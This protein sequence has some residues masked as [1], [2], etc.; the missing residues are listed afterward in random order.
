MGPSKPIRATPRGGWDFVSL[1]LTRKAWLRLRIQLLC[2]RCPITIDHVREATLPLATFGP[3][4]S[5]GALV[6]L[7]GVS[8]KRT[9][10]V[11]NDDRLP[12]FQLDDEIG[13]ESSR[14]LW[15]PETTLR[16]VARIANPPL[17]VFVPIN[18]DTAEPTHIFKKHACDLIAATQNEEER[19][20][21]SVGSHG[22][23]HGPSLDPDSQMAGLGEGGEGEARSD[24][25]GGSVMRR[26]LQTT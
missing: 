15:Q 7:F 11:F 26:L 9:V 4:L 20:R 1:P 8:R 14:R 18:L 12:G 3:K 22:S 21:R 6:L 10:L 2:K 24:V 16:S 13:R 23:L 5:D 17:D 25:T 19:G